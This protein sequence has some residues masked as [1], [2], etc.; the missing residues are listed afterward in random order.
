MAKTAEQVLEEISGTDS[1]DNI[2]PSEVDNLLDVGGDDDSVKDDEVTPENSSGS[3]DKGDDDGKG[4]D[5]EPEEYRSLAEL[6][7]GADR[8]GFKLN[9]T[10]TKRV[11][12][13]LSNGFKSDEDIDAYLKEK[14]EDVT[15][16][17]KSDE[18]DDKDDKNDSDS[19]SDDEGKDK[20]DG[21][22]NTEPDDSGEDDIDSKLLKVIGPHLEK[23]DSVEDA[24]TAIKNLTHHASQK[25]E[26]VNRATKLGLDTPEKIEQMVGTL[27]GID[28][29]ISSRL[30][31][32]EGLKGLY[33]SFDIPIP[34]WMG[35]VAEADGGKYNGKPAD[36]GSKK[37]VSN[38]LPADMK[39]ALDEIENDGYIGA[40]QFKDLIPSLVSHIQGNLEAKYEE[41]NVN[42]QKVGK[43]V[44]GLAKQTQQKQIITNTFQDAREISDQIGRFDENVKLKED[45]ATIW[46]E[47]I[48]ADGKLKKEVHS[49][50]K[51]LQKILAVRKGALKQI[52]EGYAKM[53][54]KRGPV[55]VIAFLSKKIVTSG[56]LL[57]MS[58]K[59]GRNA[60]QNL[61]ASLAKKLQPNLRDKKI[62]KNQDAFKAPKTENDVKNMSRT[63]RKL[64]FEKLRRGDLK[65]GT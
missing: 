60:K 21:D 29:D 7:E 42:M 36:K 45:P 55:D 64:F 53:G 22:D 19:K 8:S 63:N 9:A 61:V 2:E 50:F 31:S 4:D 51:K 1:D 37:V 59:A 27:D 34:D 33:E 26:F 3:P 32:P 52:N 28:A 24:V 46:K 44:N 14:G 49:E 43:Y 57:E 16:K 10:E 38:E 48:G 56:S 65:V 54:I 15:P 35:Q 39:T 12:I 62:N 30:Q 6:N 58:N 41:Q 13:A 17:A 20:N 47:S 18:G 23:A 40:Q 25:S 11:R 5:S